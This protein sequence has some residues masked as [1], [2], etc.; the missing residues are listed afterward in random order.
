MSV[1]LSSSTTPKIT[2]PVIEPVAEQIARPFWSVMITSYNR[3][4]Y[5]EQCIKSVLAEGFP[6]EEMQIE[7]VDDHSTKADIEK[8]VESVAPGQVSFYRQPKN[9]GIYENWNT[10]IRRARG[11][12][13]HILSDD[14][15]ILPGFYEAYRQQIKQHSCLVMV[16][17]SVFFNEKSQWTGISPAIQNY[18]GLIDDAKLIFAMGNPIRTPG[19]IVAREAYKEVGGFTSDLVY[20]PDWEMWSR[21]A[22]YVKV[23]YVNRPFSLFREHSNSETSR[24]AHAGNSVSDALRATEII[25]SRFA[26]PGTRQ[27]IQASV[28]QYLCNSCQTLSGIFVG[29]GNYQA[30]LSQATLAMQVKLSFYSV[31]NFLS[32]LVKISVSFTRSK[33]KRRG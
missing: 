29:E 10:C 20:T 13:I 7:V 30:A 8:I 24:L 6:P 23:G 22:A 25:Q 2:F 11:Y 18:S 33:A 19:I 27:L 3:T 16:G 5:L 15:Q 12:W 28:R 9:V 31:K 21:L 32:V 26:D 4:E 14:D 1:S 17:Q